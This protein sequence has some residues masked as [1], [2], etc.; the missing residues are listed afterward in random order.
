V[1]RDLDVG[2]PVDGEFPPALLV[3]RRGGRKCACA[4]NQNIGLEDVEYFGRR[5]L[6]R[7]V[8]RQNFDAGDLLRQLPKRSLLSRHREHACAV[9][10]G[11]FYDPPSYPS[12][13]ADHDHGLACQRE[14]LVLLASG[15]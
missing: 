3:K 14:H 6:I 2:L 4:Q 1:K 5:A 12:A 10:D 7:C 11:G 8:E 15:G 9:A 13:P